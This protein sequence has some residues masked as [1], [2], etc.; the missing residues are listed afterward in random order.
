VTRAF[1]I[2]K[3]EDFMNVP[4]IQVSAHEALNKLEDYRWLNENQ[5]TREDERLMKLYKMVSNGARVINVAAAF[6]FA[7]LNDKGQPKLAISRADYKSVWFHPRMNFERWG[8]SAGGG[9]F[10]ELQSWEWHHFSKNYCL[11][12]NTFDDT[13]LTNQ[14][15]KTRVPHI[16]PHI[17]PTIALKNFHILF[18]VENWEEYPVDPYLLRHIDGN[19]FVV[20]AEWELTELEAALLGSMTGH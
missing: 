13:L 2:F 5:R 10:S 12:R 11:P 15:L 6:K 20:V 19:L 7:G 3:K 9:G 1:Q 17:R 8:R 14:A 16:P 18:E 4:L